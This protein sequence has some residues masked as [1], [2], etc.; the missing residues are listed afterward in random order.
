MKTG[1]L[2]D[3]QICISVP[4]SFSFLISLALQNFICS[5][6]AWK[7][8]HMLRSYSIG[9]S[10]ANHSTKD[11]IFMQ[12]RLTRTTLRLLT[13]SDQQNPKL[14]CKCSPDQQ[15][16]IVIILSRALIQRYFALSEQAG[17]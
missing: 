2:V 10:I 5:R 12:I 15:N 1:I 9:C 7:Y 16:N 3:F 6:P 13:V 8:V 14:V 17:A 11:P 4:F